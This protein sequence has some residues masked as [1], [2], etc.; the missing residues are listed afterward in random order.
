MIKY[1][2]LDFSGVSQRIPSKNKLATYHLQISALVPEIFRLKKCEKYVKKITDDVIH[3]DIN[4]ILYQ[5]L[6]K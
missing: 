6:Y 4:P 5:I 3:S 2:P 1:L